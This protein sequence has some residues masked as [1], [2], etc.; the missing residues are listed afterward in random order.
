MH[1]GQDGVCVLVKTLVTTLGGELGQLE[2]GQVGQTLG[3]VNTD[4]IVLGDELRQVEVAQLGHAPVSVK[5]RVT[6]VAKHVLPAPTGLHEGPVVMVLKA[7]TVLVL[8]SHVSCE[9]DVTVVPGSAG[10][11]MVNGVHFP[12]AADM[13]T[14]GEQVPTP[15]ASVQLDLRVR[16]DTEGVQEALEGQRSDTVCVETT[17]VGL[18]V[19]TPPALVQL[20]DEQFP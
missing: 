14:E 19:W 7:L 6:V 13:T 10:N 8:A 11:V 4:V 15:P 12:E 16:V 20:D 2:G 3:E 9:H 17:V 18:Q 1:E 5:E